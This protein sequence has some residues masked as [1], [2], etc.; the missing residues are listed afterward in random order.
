MW[1][2]VRSADNFIYNYN[3]GL[4]AFPEQRNNSSAVVGAVLGTLTTVLI[5]TVMITITVLFILSWRVSLASA[6]KDLM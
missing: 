4:Y 2:I 5:I 3:I 6:Y 1:V